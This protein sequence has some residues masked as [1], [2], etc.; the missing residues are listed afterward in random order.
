MQIITINKKNNG[1]YVQRYRIM[2]SFNKI[3]FD[4]IFGL[5]T[6]FLMIFLLN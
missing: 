3:H 6:D 2:K 4:Y 5:M 1:N